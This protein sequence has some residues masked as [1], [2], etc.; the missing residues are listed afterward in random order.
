MLGGEVPEGEGAFYPPTILIDVSP[1]M[2]AYDE[3]L[4]GPV[5]SVIRAQ[6]ESDAIKIANDSSYGL[7]AGIFSRDKNRAF[8]IAIEQIDTGACFINDYVKSN[9]QLPFGGVK[10]SGHGRELSHHGIKEFVNIKTVCIG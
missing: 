10:D 7:G 3:E 4:F 1:G 6:S 5:A 9:P 8:K 2:P